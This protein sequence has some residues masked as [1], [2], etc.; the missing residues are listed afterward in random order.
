MDKIIPILKMVAKGYLLVKTAMIAYKGVALALNVVL[1]AQ[2]I[3]LKAVDT[4]ETIYI[5]TLY[6]AEFATKVLNAAIAAGPWGWLAMAIGAA[7]VAGAAFIACFDDSSESL[8]KNQEEI[9]KTADAVTSFKE[10]WENSKIRPIQFD[11]L[12]SGDGLTLDEIDTKIDEVENK[13]SE[14]LKS[15]FSEQQA[16]RNKDIENIK[17]YQKE[18][19]ELEVS[20][21]N[22]YLKTMN[23]Q[24]VA[25]KQLDSGNYA[26]IIDAAKLLDNNTES[27]TEAKESLEKT[28]MATLTDIENMFQGETQITTV[29]GVVISKDKAIKDAKAAY[30]EQL[31]QLKDSNKSMLDE[32]EKFTSEAA[33][34]LS[35]KSNIWENISAGL[36]NDFGH[37]GLFSGNGA[38]EYAENLSR[39]DA[40]TMEATN[41]FMGAVVKMRQQGMELS[42]EIKAQAKNVL[43]SFNTDDE[44]MSDIG[45]NSLLGVIKGLESEIPGLGDAVT[46][47]AKEIT[48]TMTEYLGIH[49]PSVVMGEIGMYTIQG[50]QIGML[51]QLP[52]LMLTL[53]TISASISNVFRNIKLN[54]IGKNIIIGLQNGIINQKGKLLTAVRGMA[55]ELNNAFKTELDI[56]SPSRV[57]RRNGQMVGEGLVLGIKDRMNDIQ[58]SFNN[59]NTDMSMGYTPENSVVNSSNSTHT[60]NNNISPTINVTVNGGNGETAERTKYALEELFEEFFAGYGRRS[61]RITQV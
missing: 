3:W 27:Y 37:K 11:K 13:I 9:K 26:D 15:R 41:S 47:S 7:C 21:L 51:T 60:E 24:K 34:K 49:S 10:K 20:K 43:N 19:E 59:L 30:D 55:Q 48:D 14:V 16:L 56:H 32:V 29:E 23:S 44:E 5:S 22:T 54:S 57:M 17:K 42:D 45:K 8:Q 31:K 40:E 58:T 2:Q 18:V 36:V 35:L 6:A 38:E 25:L 61:P 12:I 28:Y 33:E 4:A 53:I 46:M 39:I 1:K 50:L 52:F